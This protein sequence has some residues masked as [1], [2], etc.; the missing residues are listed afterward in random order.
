MAV[1]PLAGLAIGMLAIGR[2]QVALLGLFVVVA[3]VLAWWLDGAGRLKRI[4]TTMAPLAISAATA[5]AVAIV[6]FVFSALLAANSNRPSYGLAT[7]GTVR[8]TRTA[9]DAGLRTSTAPPILW[10]ISGDRRANL[11]APHLDQPT[12]SS[13]SQNMGEIYC[14]ILAVILIFGIGISRGL[15]WTRDIRLFSRRCS[16]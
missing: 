2:D 4:R 3:Y 16:W 9:D 1:A 11:G 6:P 5:F 7:W 13:F 10:S 8:S 12:S 14:G 15:L